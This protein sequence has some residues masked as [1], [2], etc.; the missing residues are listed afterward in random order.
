MTPSRKSDL[1]FTV[2]QFA[3]MLGTERE[4]IL[5]WLRVGM[6]YVSQGNWRTG[7]GF[8]IRLHHAIEWLGLAA[9]HVEQCNDKAAFC[10]LRLDRI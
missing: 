1:Q 4:T 7:E 10:A 9:G 5:I 6:P 3:K 2:D 8:S